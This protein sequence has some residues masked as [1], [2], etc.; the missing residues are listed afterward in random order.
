MPTTPRLDRPPVRRAFSILDGLRMLGLSAL[1]AGLCQAQPADDLLRRV[2]P[3]AGLT[4]VVEDLREHAEDWLRSPLAADL[5]RLSE[6]GGWPGDETLHRLAIARRE[7]EIALNIDLATIRDALLGDAVVLSMHL[8]PG[9]SPEE[10]Q[11]LLLVQARDL[12]LL[13]RLVERLNAAERVAGQL[14]SLEDREHSGQPYTA[15]Q[16][17]GDHR[18]PEFYTILDDGAFAW[19]N[20]ESLIQGVIDRSGDGPS[21]LGDEPAFQAVR[22]ALPE[23]S[24]V[25]LFVDPGFVR[26]VLEADPGTPP[27]ADL[28]PLLV[29]YLR[30]IRYAGLALE[31]RDGPVLHLHESIDTDRLS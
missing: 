7:I 18:R 11:G 27:E 2:P 21:G 12:D 29:N 30:A 16:F 17:L 24:V 8:E 26:K 25:S 22:R 28:P 10:A 3:G 23:R 9:A 4:V 19:S 1:L 5:G 31:W 20:S 13:R 14:E 15:R 6:Q